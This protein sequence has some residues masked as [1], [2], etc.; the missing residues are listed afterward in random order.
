[1]YDTLTY[2]DASISQAMGIANAFKERLQFTV[3]PTNF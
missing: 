2:Y 1:M 3:L